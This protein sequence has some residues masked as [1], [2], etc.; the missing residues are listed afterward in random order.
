LDGVDYCRLGLGGAILD[1][2]G[3]RIPRWW[4]EGKQVCR[5]ALSIPVFQIGHNMTYLC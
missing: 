5:F 2:G 3:Y 1:L 4:G